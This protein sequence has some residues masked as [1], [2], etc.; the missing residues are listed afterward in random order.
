MTTHSHTGVLL[1]SIH[2]YRVYAVYNR[3]CTHGDENNSLNGRVVKTK[4]NITN[5]TKQTKRNTLFKTYML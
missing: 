1:Y 2:D 4:D 3:D 5:G